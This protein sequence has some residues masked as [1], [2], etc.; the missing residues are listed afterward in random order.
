[1][2]IAHQ[3]PPIL[4]GHHVRPD[5]DRIIVQPPDG[6]LVWRPGGIVHELHCGRGLGRRR[7]ADKLVDFAID[8]ATSH[9]YALHEAI[10]VTDSDEFSAYIEARYRGSIVHESGKQ[11]YTLRLRP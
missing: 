5:L 10:F 7:L 4:E 11:V 2:E 6:C 1:M 9:P 3:L 8:D